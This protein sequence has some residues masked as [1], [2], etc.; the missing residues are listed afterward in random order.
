M[1]VAALGHQPSQRCDIASAEHGTIPL[2]EA[3]A[4]AQTSWRVTRFATLPHKPA[5]CHTRRISFE[6]GRR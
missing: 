3:S 1:V 4:R 6:R 5:R 2:E